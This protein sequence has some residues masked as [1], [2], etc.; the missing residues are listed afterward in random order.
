M[1]P[2]RGSTEFRKFMFAFEVG[3]ARGSNPPLMLYNLQEMPI[4][5]M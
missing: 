5:G 4:S 1:A 2:T 3:F